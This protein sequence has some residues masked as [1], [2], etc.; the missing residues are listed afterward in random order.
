MAELIYGVE[1]LTGLTKKQDFASMSSGPMCA[2]SRELTLLWMLWT[3]A[4][5]QSDTS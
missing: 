1:L 4:M 3:N 2:S 5:S